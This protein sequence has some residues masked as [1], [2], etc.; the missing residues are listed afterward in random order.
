MTDKDVDWHFGQTMDIPLGER[1]AIRDARKAKNGKKKLES[2]ARRSSMKS[3]PKMAR[4]WR[5]SFQLQLG[6]SGRF[7]DGCSEAEKWG[8]FV[9]DF[10]AFWGKN[11]SKTPEMGPKL[12]SS[13]YLSVNYV[14]LYIIHS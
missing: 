7:Q 8:H 14:F 13:D 5:S 2:D 12:G 4:R 10:G 6:A 1:I 11:G 9:V 3:A